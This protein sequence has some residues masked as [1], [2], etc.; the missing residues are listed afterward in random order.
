[1]SGVINGW[2]PSSESIPKKVNR[3][4]VK[5]V[6]TKQ[7][8]TALVT[9][10]GAVAALWVSFVVIALILMAILAGPYYAVFIPVG[11]VVI[12]LVGQATHVFRVPYLLQR[13][14]DVADLGVVAILYLGVVALY[15][16]AFVG[17]GTSST[18]GLFLSFAAGL[19]LGVVGPIVYTVW[20]RNRPLHTLGIGRDRI[21]ATV[22]LAL[23]FAAVQ[24][25]ITLWGYRLPAAVEWVPLLVMSVVVGLFEA[26]FFRGFVQSALESSFGTGPAILGA[27]GLYSLYHFGYG[28]GFEQ[29]GFLFALGV[30]YAV[31]Y[32]LVRNILVLWPLL[33]PLGAFFSRLQDGGLAGQLPW[34]SILGFG[35]VL[36]VM[37]IV[38]W[39]ASRHGHKPPTHT[40]RKPLTQ[41]RAVT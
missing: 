23:L 30:V 41:W 31:A 34:L 40:P 27:A 14:V 10:S 32:S 11:A 12:A 21:G 33:T 25:S 36:L 18:A 13:H 29:M 22:A 3:V 37:G 26:V 15:R 5:N 38:V 19:L 16:L 8:Q 28:M 24:F 2:H 9:I 7:P 20:L 6:E 39:V 17:F 1:M 4:M 35:E